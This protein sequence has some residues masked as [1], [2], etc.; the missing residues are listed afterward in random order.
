MTTV[1]LVTKGSYSDY[2]IVAAYSTREMAERVQQM[3]GGEDSEVWVEDY[4]V[5]TDR[6]GLIREG[7]FSVPRERR[8][9]EPTVTE[10]RWMRGRLTPEYDTRES[11]LSDSLDKRRKPTRVTYWGEHAAAFACARAM[12]MELHGEVV[13]DPKMD[14]QTEAAG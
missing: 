14:R 1:W 13:V 10:L 5:H 6:T 9:G 12:S 3:M 4:E 2:G 11:W 7:S 8:S